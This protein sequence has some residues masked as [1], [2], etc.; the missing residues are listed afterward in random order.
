MYSMLDTDMKSP[1]QQS[2]AL[3]GGPGTPGGKGNTSTPDQ[4]RVKRPMN[5]FMVW[6]RGQRRKMAQ[7]N[8]KMHNSEISKRLGADWKLLSDS[9]KRP[10][11]DEAKR[12]RAV[13]MKDYPDYKYRPRRKTK[14][15]LKKDKYSLPG[16][17]LAPGINPV[18]GGVGQR[19]DTYPHMNGWTNGAYSLM[20]EQL[21][22]GQHPA[23]NSS[24]MQQIQHRYD[25]GGLQYSPMMSSAQTYMNA[26]A[27]TYSMSPAYNQQSSTVMSLASMGSVVKSEPSSP[28]PAITSHTQRACLGDLRDM[29]SMYLPPGGDAGDHSS[30]QNSRLHSVHQHYQSAGGP[31]VNGTVPLTHI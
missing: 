9:E 14:T 11:I 29:I 17:L 2:N 3:S 28:P 30:L 18:S 16:N 24:Q 22:Y 4:D 21:G 27:S 20:Q 19:I 8:P 15:L 6:S 23:M 25:M 7:E 5:A 31:G 26:A 12:L 1:V 10:F 13:H